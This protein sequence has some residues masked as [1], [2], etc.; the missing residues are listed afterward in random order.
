MSDIPSPQD[1][2]SFIVFFFPGFISLLVTANLTGTD[3][4][5]RSLVEVI[6]VSFVFSAIN[7]ALASLVIPISTITAALLQIETTPLYSIVIFGT[8]ILIGVL[9]YGLLGV[10]LTLGRWIAKAS[11]S[12]RRKLLG[13]TDTF[14]PSSEYWLQRVFEARDKNDLIVTTRS[15][16]LYKGKL[17]SFSIKPRFEVI[18]GRDEETINEDGKETKRVRP[19][20]KF[21][22]NGWEELV[23]WAILFP[24]ED[25][26][27]LLVVG[28]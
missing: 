16:E 19:V 13:G 6:V 22:D 12:L 15:D 14:G 3:L 28:V 21:R 27:R 23:E 1:V 10:W 4:K 11:I 2:I 26:R 7:L 25:I 9:T 18:L 5:D 17:T 20:Y 24:E 8:S